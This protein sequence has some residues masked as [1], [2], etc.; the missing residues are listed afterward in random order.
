MRAFSFVAVLLCLTSA[1]LAQ[2]QPQSA[3]ARLEGAAV[4][5]SLPRYEAELD[6]IRRALLKSTLESAPTRVLSTAW[7]DGQGQLHES[8]QFASEARVRGVRVLSYLQDPPVPGAPPPVVVS[9]ESLPAGLGPQART[10]PAACADQTQRWRQ[11][12]RLLS[13]QAPGLRGEQAHAGELLL[14]LAGQ[15][16]LAQ[17]QSSQRWRS[18]SQPVYTPSAYERMLLGAPEPTGGW[19]AVLEIAPLAPPAPS[20]WQRVGW[21]P[22]SAGWAFE[23]RLTVSHPLADDALWRVSERIEISTAARAAGPAHWTTELAE[24]L[25]ERMSRWQ[26][27]LD[28]L[29][30][31]EPMAFEVAGVTGVAGPTGMAGTAGPVG[32]WQLLAGSRHGLRPGDRVLL[33]DRRHLPQRMLEAGAAQHLALAEVQQVGPRSARLRQ[34]AG[35]ALAGRGDWVALPF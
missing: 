14:G 21:Q 18:E 2:S 10:E 17:M 29:S 30:A 33:M 4:A 1:A 28:Q 19:Q 8:T 23:L 13:A 5:G 34:L 11:P 26:Q 16:W 35:P 15:A 25:Q 20:P 6:A 7:I 32:V 24:R 12:L 27:Q 22:P 3:P 31:C 9:A